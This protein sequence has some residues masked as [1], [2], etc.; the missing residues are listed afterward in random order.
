MHF[1]ITKD[2]TA[3][4]VRNHPSIKFKFGFGQVTFWCCICFLSS[5]FIMFA[6]SNAKISWIWQDGAILLLL[7]SY[8]VAGTQTPSVIVL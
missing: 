7:V 1:P 8:L 4:M 3:D 2:V 6:L 5:C